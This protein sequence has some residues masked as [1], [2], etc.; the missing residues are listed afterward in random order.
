M[1]EHDEFDL[2][3]RDVEDIHMDIKNKH[4][5]NLLLFEEY[6]IETLMNSS[7]NLNIIEPN[8]KGKTTKITKEYADNEE[9]ET[10]VKEKDSKDKEAIF[11]DEVNAKF[12][13]P[14]MHILFGTNQRDGLPVVWEP[15]NTD[16]LF[17]TNMGII[18]TMGTGK[19]QFTK[20]LITQLYRDQSKNVGGEP[21]GILIF[22]YK[23]DYNES[24]KDFMEATH[25]NILKPYQIPF[26]PLALIKSMCFNH[27]CE[28]LRY[29]L[30]LSFPI[31]AG[32]HS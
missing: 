27:S 19:T 10:A 9:N 22:D 15:N 3:L 23:G 7:S 6:K 16:V 4:D 32:A 1:L 29:M 25:A 17:H 5:N 20:S 13:G 28:S 12:K 26:N 14:G 11:L 31:T 24:K 30:F 21:L 18:G 8:G 2:I